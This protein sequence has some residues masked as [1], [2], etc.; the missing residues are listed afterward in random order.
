MNKK[1]I[2]LILM[3]DFT[4][5]FPYN[6]LKG[7]LEY[8]KSHTPW[9]VCRMPPAYK[10]YGLKGVLKWAKEWQ[11]DAIIGQFDNGD[12]VELFREHGIVALA[13][14]YKS[15]FDTIPNITSDYRLTGRMAAEFFLQRGFRHFA[16]CGYKNA[17]WSQE[18]CEGF[19]SRIEE[20][21]LAANFFEYRKQ[22]LENQW[23]HGSASLLEWLKSLPRS[24]ALL[25]CDD[26]QGNR[27]TE[28]CKVND[29]KVPD[30]IAIMGIDNDEII[31]NLSDPPLSSIALNIAGGGFEAARLIEQLMKDPAG[32]YE[33]VVI[34]PVNI[35][36]RSST[37]SYATNDPHILTALH[38][39]HGH[40]DA[41]ITVD[42]IVRQVP[43][44]RRLLEIRFRQATNQSIAK[45][46]FN[47]RMER[48]SHLLLSTNEPITT[49][50][51]EV[52][53][54]NYSNVARQF[55]KLNRGT[56]LEYRKRNRNKGG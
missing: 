43:L 54:T 6:L 49:V 40:L 29:I 10:R 25:A 17:V 45:Y 46:I 52:G 36:N 8:S 32:T 47:Q 28:V 34:Q 5:A 44:S 31:C 26:N 16:F 3:T 56:P 20:Q 38:Y 27:I 19:F 12:P 22:P 53:L 18:R 50:A 1:T 4:E 11:A 48:F 55:N 42:D 14:D 30:E 51:A 2:R 39:I 35:I 24:T 7:I 21:G 15:R 13:Q 23:M 41:K 37:A 9:V 33:D